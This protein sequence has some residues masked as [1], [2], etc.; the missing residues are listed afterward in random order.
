VVIGV[1]PILRTSYSPVISATWRSLLMVLD[2]GIRH[3]GKIG[4]CRIAPL[5]RI[6]S[7]LFELCAT[8]FFDL[9]DTNAGLL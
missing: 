8:F 1:P 5:S 7:G 4:N 9:S 6:H 2:D 3:V